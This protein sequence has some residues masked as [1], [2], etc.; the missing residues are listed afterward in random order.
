[1]NNICCKMLYIY[2]LIISNTLCQL[3]EL[4]W[5]ITIFLWIKKN[6]FWMTPVKQIN[7]DLASIKYFFQ[8][9]ILEQ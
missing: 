7:A 4:H 8:R 5:S 9:R 6:M 2:Q 3:I 1:M